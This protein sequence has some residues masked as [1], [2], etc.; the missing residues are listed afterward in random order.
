MTPLDH[1][2]NYAG[3]GLACFPCAI[4]ERDGK[5]VKLPM[6]KR[7]QE[8]A[9]TDPAQL[10]E[11]WGRWPGAMIG[12]A[13]A[14]TGTMALDI[15]THH[16]GANGWHT[17]MNHRIIG[18]DDPY[19][20]AFRS[21]SGGAQRLF[22]RPADLA[23]LAGNF[24]GS[25][26]AGLDAIY[27]YS[28][29][30]S[31]P[32]TPGREWVNAPGDTWPAPAP[33][34]VVAPAR[35][36]AEHLAALAMLPPAQSLPAAP[37]GDG[38]SLT[39]VARALE[40]ECD[41]IRALGAGQRQTGLHRAAGNVGRACARAD[42]ADLAAWCSDV[43]ATAAPWCNTAHERATIARAIAWGLTAGRI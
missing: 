3:N 21:A 27:G 6:V 28:I 34:W 24:P 41:A 25:F 1:A 30:P 40:G 29:L 32:A 43:L 20:L 10:A 19:T 14:L 16:E 11:W 35:A 26:G 17:L 39:Y 5:R 7:W 42:R 2:L 8:I 37:A 15:D 33:A 18:H 36:R 13:H 4:V 31:G 23:T 12:I 9:S 38:R 22:L